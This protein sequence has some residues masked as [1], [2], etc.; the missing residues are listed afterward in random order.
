M[1]DPR[2]HS[3]HRDRSAGPEDELG[4][5]FSPGEVGECGG[6]VGAAHLVVRPAEALEQGAVVVEQR[7]GPLGQPIAGADVHADEVTARAGGHAGGAPDEV[8]AARRA[9]ERDHDP[10]PRL[11]GVED[12]VGDLVVVQGVVDLV[13]DPHQ[14]ELAERA[15]VADAE[16]V[17]ERGVDLLGGVD[18]AVGHPPAQRLRCHVD[19]LHLVGAP[20]DLVGDRLLLLDPGDALDDVVERL[21]VL[22][23]QRGDDVDAGVAQLLDVLP[24]LLVPGPGRVGV[25]QLVDERDRGA[26]ARSPRR[27]PSPRGSCRGTTPA[28]GGST[29]RPAICSSVLRP[30]VGLDVGDDDVGAALGAAGA[31]R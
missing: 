13:G 10:F 27:C 2:V 30:T 24:A 23:V 8:L 15:E 3:A 7:R 11:P 12:P 1:T 28:A 29:S 18:V 20:G 16:V 6:D 26:H 21:E 31:P 5:L 19:Q 4:R 22:D 9:G 17:A 14:R 25:G